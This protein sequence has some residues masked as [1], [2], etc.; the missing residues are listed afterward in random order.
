MSWF[1]KKPREEKKRRRDGTYVVSDPAKQKTSF[2]KKLYGR[3]SV[4]AMKAESAELKKEMDKLLEEI[5]YSEPD[6]EGL[7]EAVDTRITGILDMIEESL[8][9]H[10]T[11]KASVHVDQLKR[12]L[13]ERNARLREGNW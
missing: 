4:L 3:L 6:A 8:D 10:N 13:A 2:M 11:G 12:L 7:M 1:S 5:R 9:E